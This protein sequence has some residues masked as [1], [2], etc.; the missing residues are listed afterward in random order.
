MVYELFIIIFELCNGLFFFTIFVILDVQK[1]YIYVL[2]PRWILYV[3]LPVLFVLRPIFTKY[4][5]CIQHR[6]FEKMKPSM[7]DFLW[8]LMGCNFSKRTLLRAT[9]RNVNKVLIPLFSSPVMMVIF[10]A[11]KYPAKSMGKSGFY[12]LV[13][14]SLFKR[15]N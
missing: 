8:L 14:I 4:F 5:H 2:L 1:F 13:I 10:I 6:Y 9:G 15:Y 3:F 11:L 7:S 12:A